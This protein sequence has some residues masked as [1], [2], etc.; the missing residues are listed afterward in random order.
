MCVPAAPA[1]QAPVLKLNGEP[2][3]APVAGA[4][5]E[6]LRPSYRLLA[7]LRHLRPH[8]VL[9]L[10]SLPALHGVP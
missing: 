5:P 1:P 4:Q 3:T 2:R 9:A 8:P 10:C 7:A 6:P